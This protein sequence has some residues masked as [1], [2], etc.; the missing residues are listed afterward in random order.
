M[1]NEP[2]KKNMAIPKS[3]MSR[4]NITSKN[5]K[6]LFFLFMLISMLFINKTTS[7]QI[8]LVHTFDESVTWTGT[9]YMEQNL[10][11]SNIYY[12]ANVVDNSYVVKIYNADYSLNTNDTYYFTPPTGYKV[13]TVTMSREIFNTDNNYEFLVNYQRTDNTYDNTRQKLILYNQN[14]SII[15]DF[16][17]AYMVT[18]YPYL[19]I[20]NDSFRL[21]VTKYYYDGTDITTQTE[22]YSV[23]GNPTTIIPNIKPNEIQKPYPN[24][25]SSIITLPYQ[26]KQG[27]ISVMH[28]YNNNGQLIEIKQIDSIFDKLLLNVSNYNKGVYFYV[29]NG[30]TNKFVVY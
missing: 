29:F 20:A 13:S 26:L 3:L 12:S 24:P 4:K 21:I 8:N 2:I 7:S 9:P 11:P 10:Y 16:G 15:K 5:M 28:I 23:P 6:N 22:V 30:L 17:F 19:H 1:E 18:A 27:E 14:G 25:A